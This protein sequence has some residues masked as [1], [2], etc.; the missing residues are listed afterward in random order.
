LN[1]SLVDARP[2]SELGLAATRP[3]DTTLGSAR[4]QLLPTLDDALE[5]FMLDIDVRRYSS[6]VSS[7]AAPAPR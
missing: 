4:A 6:L 7:D 1:P 3:R 2:Q 5:R